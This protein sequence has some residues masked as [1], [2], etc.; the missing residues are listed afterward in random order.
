MTFVLFC[1]FSKTA[2]AFLRTVFVLLYVPA[3]LLQPH[4]RIDG[5]LFLDSSVIEP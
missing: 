3:L 5:I 4:S 2:L 1:V